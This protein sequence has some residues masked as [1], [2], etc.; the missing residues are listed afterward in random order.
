MKNLEQFINFKFQYIFD[1]FKPSNSLFGNLDQNIFNTNNI[2][3]FTKYE[4]SIQSLF[5][6]IYGSQIFPELEI[7][8]PDLNTNILIHT[9]FSFTNVIGSTTAFME[10]FKQFLDNNM[11]DQNVISEYIMSK[12]LLENTIK[13][14][15]IDKKSFEEK[16]QI[17]TNL[18]NYIQNEI[19]THNNL[20]N[21]YINNNAFQ[22]EDDESLATH[23]LK[24]FKNV[25]I[26]ENNINNALLYARLANDGF[27]DTPNHPIY[28]TLSLIY[29]KTKDDS[30]ILGNIKLEDIK[31]G[32]FTEIL[33]NLENIDNTEKNLVE[34]IEAIFKGLTVKLKNV[35]VLLKE[36]NLK[37]DEFYT[38]LKNPNNL[39]ISMGDFKKIYKDIWQYWDHMKTHYI[40]I[41]ITKP[42][43]KMRR[44][45][46]LDTDWINTIND[47][48]KIIDK[49]SN[50]LIVL[51]KNSKKLNNYIYVKDN[52][53]VINIKQINIKIDFK[54][55]QN[56]FNNL[57]FI[58]TYIENKYF[59][60]VS[61]ETNTDK[62]NT[63]YLIFILKYINNGQISTDENLIKLRNIEK[64]GFNANFTDD[65]NEISNEVLK[66]ILQEV[67]FEINQI[68][69]DIF[70]FSNIKLFKNVSMMGQRRADIL[71]DY[72]KNFEEFINLEFQ[73]IFNY[74]K[75]DN[76][77]F[78]KLDIKYF[79]SG[80]GKNY[81]DFF[82][83]KKPS[84]ANIETILKNI[85]KTNGYPILN[86]SADDLDTN[87]IISENVKFD[88]ELG[89]TKDILISFQKLISHDQN[90]DNN[91]IKYIIPNDLLITNIKALI[92]SDEHKIS[93]KENIEISTKIGNYIQDEIKS[94]KNFTRLYTSFY[95]K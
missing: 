2:E 65:N 60:L 82:Y 38:I 88:N 15:T 51:K 52:L 14:S 10:S 13:S 39:T 6:I 27:K 23:I 69:N 36:D 80:G 53:E 4:D 31:T 40:D 73:H 19:E 45:Q 58:K 94:H 11:N 17:S 47:S 29:L 68:N 77:L 64:V 54:E 8:D 24:E 43:D 74:F 7:N 16:I 48:I 67:D 1:H 25:K 85:Y 55:I 9:K 63:E 30:D 3:F 28:K 34:Y 62:K 41:D 57:E 26:T 71:V 5:K 78:G 83:N 32:N 86:I 49:I 12:N 33:N 18:G 84:T 35:E 95:R 76:S 44:K 59:N 70:D 75:P 90:M 87:I 92:L 66:L 91:I 72:L 50:E 20:T 56:S 22:S 61:D 93:I 42:L 89:S 46:S 79:E 81:H 21:T 37:D